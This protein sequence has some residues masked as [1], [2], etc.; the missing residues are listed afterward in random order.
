MAWPAERLLFSQGE[1]MVKAIR[2]TPIITLQQAEFRVFS[3]WGE[4]GIIQ[5]LIRHVPI[6]HRTFIE[7][8]V[9]DFRESNC[10]FLMM[11]D[12]WSGYVLD[13]SAADVA[14]IEL[15]PWYWRHDLRAAQA[16]ITRDNVAALLDATGFD[17]DLGILSIDLD[18]VDYWVA[19]QLVHWRPRILIME[20]NAVFG[21]ARAITVPYRGDFCRTRAHHSNLYFGASLNA[22]THLANAWGYALVGTASA[23]GNAFFVRRDVLLPPLVEASVES[24][25]TPSRFRESRDRFG[26]PDFLR[27]EARAAAIAGLPVINVITGEA[28]QL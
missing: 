8:G 22:L 14:A 9:E 27:A 16:F 4:D 24:A 11:H 20:Y 21:P 3:Q 26:V 10:R 5:H 19:A 23:G 2:D 18:G 13:A 28:E 1:L 15:A 6:R 12:N 7:F 17:R 25:Y